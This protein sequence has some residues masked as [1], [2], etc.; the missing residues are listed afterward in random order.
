MNKKIDYSPRGTCSSKM[1][2]VIDD[3]D[4]TIVDFEVVGGCNGNLKGIRSL[5]IGMKLT[6]VISKLSGITCGFKKT[7]CPDQIANALSLYLESK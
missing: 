3:T 2:F 1:T 6:D 4:D 5:I 7:S